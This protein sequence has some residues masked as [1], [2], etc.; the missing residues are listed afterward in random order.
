VT[1]RGATGI[2]GLGSA[3]RAV[4]ADL[5]AAGE[6]SPTAPWRGGRGPADTLRQLELLE[7]RGLVTVDAA[8]VYRL[9]TNPEGP[10]S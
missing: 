6:W 2:T 4:L 3:Q 7:A 5:A 10:R 8:G 9:P 1:P